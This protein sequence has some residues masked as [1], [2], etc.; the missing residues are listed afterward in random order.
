VTDVVYFVV[1]RDGVD[2]IRLG[3][4][5]YSATTGVVAGSTATVSARY[6]GFPTF[7]VR[8]INSGSVVKNSDF[9]NLA[10]EVSGNVLSLYFERVRNCN[11]HINNP[12][13]SQTKTGFVFR[14]AE[15]GITY[16]GASSITRDASGLMGWPSMPN[17]SAGHTSSYSGGSVTVDSSWNGRVIYYTGTADITLTIPK[18]M[19]YGFNMTVFANNTGN[20]TIATVSG[21]FL[22][23]KGSI[24]KTNG[25]FSRVKVEAA[26][27]AVYILSGDLQA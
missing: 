27:A 15:C 23:S 11:G 17:L 16:A 19:P 9:G 22:K 5:R 20:V 21:V 1:W 4:A 18:N 24:Y 13:P 6:S 7:M 8:S 2:K 3:E 12:S 14:D 25:Q 10:C 26:G